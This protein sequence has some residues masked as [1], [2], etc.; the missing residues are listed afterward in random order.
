MSSFPSNISSIDRTLGYIFILICSLLILFVLL[1]VKNTLILYTL[2]IL[3]AF[4][5]IYMIIFNKNAKEDFYS[6]EDNINVH[7]SNNLIGTSIF[8]IILSIEILLT[9]LNESIE[10]PPLLF[11]LYSIQVLLI[12]LQIAYNKNDKKTTFVILFQII[13]LGLATRLVL[14]LSTS[15]VIGVDPWYHQL[16]TQKIVSEGRIPNN[17]A[18]SFLPMFHLLIANGIELMDLDYVQSSYLLVSSA[19][20]IIL[21]LFTYILGNK[22]ISHT[23]GLFAS[24][25]VSIANTSVLFGLALIPNTMGLLFWLP[26]LYILLFRHEF[27]DRIILFFLTIAIIFTHTICAMGLFIVLLILPSSFFLIK[28]LS[29]GKWET[30]SIRVFHAFPILFGSLMFAFWIYISGS[31][32]SL[33]QLIKIGFRADINYSFRNAFLPFAVE[34][35]DIQ[36][37]TGNIGRILF[38]SIALTGMLYCVKI[39][40]QNPLLCA[41]SITSVALLALGFFTFLFGMTIISGR[42]WYFSQVLAVISV[43]LFIV[44]LAKRL[45]PSQ[46]RVIAAIIVC[47]L[48]FLM[49]I[50]SD[51]NVDNN[52]TG[53][54]TVSRLYLYESE[55]TCLYFVCDNINETFYVDT[56]YSIGFQFINSSKSGNMNNIGFDLFYNHMKTTDGAWVFRKELLNHPVLF[57]GVECRLPFNAAEYANENPNISKIYDCGEVWIFD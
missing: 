45:S 44:V 5:L 54:N 35:T 27:K 34:L 19:Q 18:Y 28:R 43:A 37:L 17:E 51:A 14:G 23:V 40:L 56:Y 39:K 22:I 47:F 8:F 13:V 6:D 3:L 30:A 38:F 12:G 36:L 26:I 15:S 9:Y 52:E 53:L 41:Y 1:I 42:W 31:I 11:I 29:T 32:L 33:G 46:W 24:L 48:C 57:N 10:R 2:I 25:I 49:F 4:L 16:F 21:A 55:I 20:V 50:S 7:Y